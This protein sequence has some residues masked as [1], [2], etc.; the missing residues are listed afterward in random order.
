MLPGRR[1]RFRNPWGSR[2]VIL[3]TPRFARTRL[4]RKGQTIM[5][6]A[7]PVAL[8]A[9]L[10]VLMAGCGGARPTSSAPTASPTL[11][12]VPT[13]R[14]SGPPREPTDNDKPTGWIV[15]TVTAGGTGPC[16]GLV[17]DD[18]IKYALH[19]TAGT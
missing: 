19:S 17:T 18:G 10:A 2:R 16:Y 8:A 6:Y 15:G 4:G 9:M 13:S 7:R 12:S 3:G 11:E 5:R 1:P 14:P